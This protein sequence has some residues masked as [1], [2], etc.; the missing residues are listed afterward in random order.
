LV[1]TYGPTTPVYLSWALSV[2]SLVMMWA[3]ALRPRWFARISAPGARVLTAIRDRA[4][5]RLDWNEDEG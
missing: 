5:A 2:L 1:F 3:W 4:G